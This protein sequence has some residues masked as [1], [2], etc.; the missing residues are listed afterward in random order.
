MAGAMFATLRPA[1]AR[2]PAD[3][4]PTHAELDALAGGVCTARGMPVRFV[5]P[6]ELSG[7]ERLAYESHIARTGEV[8][9]RPASWHDL[10][11][12]LAWIT[13][14][15]AKARINAQHV[16]I[17]EARGAAELRRRSPARDALTL[18]DEGGVVVAS[19]DRELLALVEA[20]EWKALFWHRR[21][22]VLAKMRFFAFGHGAFE[23]G[24]APYIGMVAKTVFVP[25]ERAF[26]ALPLEGQVARAD[27]L[28][29]AHFAD[30]ARFASPKAMAPLPLLGIPGWH[31][32]AQDEAFY[33]D[34][35]YFRSRPRGDRR[36]PPA[37]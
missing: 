21:D 24:L 5:P 18:F 32:A 4:W 37:L 22:D 8:P 12:A 13:W 25:A 14:P 30:P 27:A 33:D 28:L 34:A 6:R 9:T 23:Q 20:F 26:L 29:D 11:N 19:A 2:L 36:A 1:L 7:D 10:F 3:R 35:R 16:A 17:L 15:R 31:F